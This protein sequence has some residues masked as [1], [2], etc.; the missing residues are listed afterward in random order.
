MRR[1]FSSSLASL[2]LSLS[3]AL[4]LAPACKPSDPPTLAELQAIG[5][6]EKAGSRLMDSPPGLHRLDADAGPKK[7][8]VVAVHGLESKGKEWIDPLLALADNGVELHFFRWND[9]QC[10]DAGARDLTAALRGLVKARPEIERI[11]VLAHSYGGVISTLVAQGEGLG[12][13]VELHIIASPLASVPKL[14]DICD[15]AGVPGSAAGAAVSWRQWRTVH[16]EDGAFKDLEVD[17]Q[18]VDLPGLEVTSLPATFEGGRL[19]HNRSIT[20]VTR[21]LDPEIVEGAPP[22]KA[23][24]EPAPTPTPAEVAPPAEAGVGDPPADGAAAAE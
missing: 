18:V 8:A 6:A 23:E 17:P 1:I 10:P 20:F 9:R 13:P 16:S 5:D 3:L 4:A 21:E 11:T 7:A 12:V 2:T 19:G 14:R 22:A 15:F 24:P